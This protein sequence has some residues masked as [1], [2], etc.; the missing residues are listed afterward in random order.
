MSIVDNRQPISLSEAFRHHVS[1]RSGSDR[2]LSRF[3]G[4]EAGWPT[5]GSS[6]PR[7]FARASSEDGDDDNDSSDSMS[8]S[9]IIQRVP[10]LTRGSSVA[11]SDS[12]VQTDTASAVQGGYVLET[13]DGILTLPSTSEPDADLLCPFQILD[14]EETFSSVREFKTHVF[15]HFR[16]HPLPTSAPCFLCLNRF[17]QEPEDDDALAWNKMLSHMA[18]DHFRQGQ[19]LGTIR[20]DFAL[21]RWMYDRKIISDHYFKR[22]QIHPMPTVLP[23]ASRRASAATS[24][25]EAPSPPSPRSPISP[26]SPIASAPS[27]PSWR[28]GYQSQAYVTF[29]GRRE[30]RRRRDSTRPFVFQARTTSR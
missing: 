8:S 25:P 9:F 3:N 1:S 10:P 16:G 5:V 22:T 19:Q 11:S 14:C 20:A 28:G 7:D 6:Y 17:T 24:I 26:I 12:A 2:T 29:A 4:S 21:M 18:S 27:L 15:S 13:D 23:A 30:E